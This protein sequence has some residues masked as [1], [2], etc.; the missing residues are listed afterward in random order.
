[1]L[2]NCLKSVLLIS[3]IISTMANAELIISPV[4]NP[5][6]LNIPINSQMPTDQSVQKLM[7]VLHINEM[8]DGV[9]NQHQAFAT[10]MADMPKQLPTADNK[11]T[12]IFSR[13]VEKQIQQLF[14]KYSQ[15]FAQTVDPEKQRQT[16]I[17]AYLQTAKQRYTQAEVNALLGFYDNPMGQQIL[18]KQNQVN[19]DFLQTVMPMLVGDT[20]VLQQN[21]PQIQQDIEK[22]FR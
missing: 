19:S 14:G 8:I 10:A 1:M 6:T 22:I 2:K 11:K 18:Q 5:T 3:G 21:L 9:V 20:A 7:Q 13:Q 12:T 16:L 4:S 15:V 17:S